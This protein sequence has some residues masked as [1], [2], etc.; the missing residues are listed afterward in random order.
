MTDDVSVVE[1]FTDPQLLGA[2]FGEDTRE[3]WR[4]VLCAAFGLPLNDARST[5]FQRLSGGRA[6][7]SKRVR[8]LWAI[9]GRR[10]DK[11]HTAAGVAVYLAAIGAE[12][13]GTLSRLTAGERG[14]VLVLAVDRTQARVALSYVRGLLTESP[15][16]SPMVERETAEG[17]ELTNGVSIEVATNS[18]RSVRGRTLLAA[19]MDE[20]AFY[21][22]EQSATPDVEVYRALIPSLA[23]T[24][25]MLVGISSPYARRGL[26]YQKWRKHFGKDDD[27]LVVQGGSLDFNP[28]IDTQ[29]IADAEADDPEA[30]KAEWYGQFRADVEAFITREV[31]ESVTRNEGVELAPR[32]HV[33]YFAFADPAGGGADEFTLAIGHYEDEHLITDALRARRGTPA[34]IVAEYAKLLKS[35]AVREVTADKYAG[36]WPADEFARHD[37]RVHPSSKS[38]SELYVDALAK[39][40]SGRVELPPDDRLLVQLVSLERRTSRAG[41]DSVDH[42]PGGHDDRANAVAGLLATKPPRQHSLAPPELLGE[43]DPATQMPME[44]MTHEYE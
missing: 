28:T 30:A 23:T 40:N 19:I 26:L 21:R 43:D 31:V 36:S 37:I 41:R 44:A 17:V 42:P 13:D 15:L 14:V 3:P 7:P 38:K 6:A 22:D 11:T 2:S 32:K 8:E 24:G 39:F 25:G 35:Y 4:A 16:L 20:V 29:I 33:R 9:A 27:V 10:S 1:A 5:L 12:L 18:H 34:D